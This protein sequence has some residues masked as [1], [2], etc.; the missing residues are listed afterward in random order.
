MSTSDPATSIPVTVDADAP[1]EEESPLVL[2]RATI[3]LRGVSVGQV[4][5]VDTRI[6]YI[7]RR[8]R[9]GHL[10]VVADEGKQVA[11]AH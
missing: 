9:C 3:A 6:P 8:L 1:K 5:R 11:G 7:A 10:A 4:I 2:A